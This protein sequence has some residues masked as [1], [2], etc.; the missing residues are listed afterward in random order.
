MFRVASRVAESSF[1]SGGE[2]KVTSTAFL[3]ILFIWN[4][5]IVK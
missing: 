2:S 1:W 4:C 5:R 3:R